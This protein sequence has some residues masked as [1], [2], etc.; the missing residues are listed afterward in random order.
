L[1]YLRRVIRAPRANRKG[2]FG[3]RHARGVAL[4]EAMNFLGL[5]A[6]LS[7]G[8][9]YGLARYVRHAKTAEAVG[10]VTAI[11]EAAARYYDQSDAN[12][13]AGTTPEAAH[14]MRHFPPASKASV[15]AAPDAI[16]GKRYQSTLGDWSGSPWSELRFS[17][18]QP[19]YYAYSFESQGSG[20]QATATA[21]AHADLDGNG[22][23]STY[24]L[25]ITPD[26]VT[27]KAK[28]AV[29]VEKLDPEE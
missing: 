22:K 23:A 17:I 6:L 29:E 11:A 13:P 28:V 12:Q 9:M 7:A 1:R 5:A 26:P 18:P 21:I 20:A 4:T 8:G 19:Q 16:K 27:F 14:A 2:P 3:Q 24:R 25:S 15:P 10:S